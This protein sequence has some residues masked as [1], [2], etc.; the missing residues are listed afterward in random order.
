MNPNIS[1][2]P[3][4]NVQ[5][6]QDLEAARQKKPRV[7]N[8]FHR[9]IKKLF[10]IKAKIALYL[11]QHNI[12]S[13]KP[14]VTRQIQ[15]ARIQRSLLASGVSLNNSTALPAKQVA[16]GNALYEK[17]PNDFA[18]WCLENDQP[19]PTSFIEDELIPSQM[20]EL[21]S[22]K[23]INRQQAADLS[24]TINM[25]LGLD[26]Q[27][28]NT[29]SEQ[30]RNISRVKSPLT[31]DDKLSISSRFVKLMQT[32]TRAR[33]QVALIIPALQAYS[34]LLDSFPPSADGASISEQDYQCYMEFFVAYLVNELPNM[35]M[36]DAKGIMGRFMFEASP[37]L[38]PGFSGE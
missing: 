30:Q 3:T 21:S 36:L 14:M 11:R 6:H 37:A 31:R 28:T 17:N 22:L 32:D 7:Q 1:K 18:L 34:D 23:G 24:L 15:A 5:L 27:T 35:S 16:L 25:L 38:L 4:S 33:S 29:S 2:T 20:Q 26:Y 8:H 9:T 12:L 10:K 13:S 19:L